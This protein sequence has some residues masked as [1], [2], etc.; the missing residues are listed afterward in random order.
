MRTFFAYLVRNRKKVRFFLSVSISKVYFFIFLKKRPNRDFC[1]SYTFPVF[2]SLAHLFLKTD[3]TNNF[4]L[5]QLQ[6]NINMVA[7]LSNNAINSIRPGAV[8][9]VTG[10]KNELEAGQQVAEFLESSNRNDLE[11]FPISKNYF[12]LYT[13]SGVSNSGIA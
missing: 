6:P 10:A 7:T 9:T 1:W 13:K 3:S 5:E 8:L 11:F 2:G 12:L 4:T